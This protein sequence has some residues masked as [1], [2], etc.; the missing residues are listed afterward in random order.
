MTNSH[1]TL[2]KFWTEAIGDDIFNWQVNVFG[3]EEGTPMFQDMIRYEQITGRNW[4]Q[5]K[6]TFP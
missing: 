1:S 5:M 2:G 6:V 4:V 3:F